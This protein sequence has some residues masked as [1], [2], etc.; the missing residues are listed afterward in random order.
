MISKRASSISPSL[1]FSILEKAQKLQASGID[2]INFSVGEPDFSTAEYI[3]TAAKKAM[4]TG[5]TKYT[6]TGGVEPLR[7]AI[8]EK[9]KKDNGLQYSPDQIIVSNG[10]KQSLDNALACLVDPGDEVILFS[11]YWLTYPELVKICGGTPVIVECD[12]ANNYFPT[13]EQL[14]K[15]I[16]PKT[17]VILLNTPCN[18]SGAV[19]PEKVI[20]ELAAVIEKTD[21]YVISD[22]IYEKLIYDGT[23]HYSIAAYSKKLYEK[24]IVINGFSKAFAM[25]GWRV[26]YLAASPKIAKAVIAFQSHVTQ[27]INTPAQY[28]AIEALSN[29]QGDT[30]L[31]QMIAEFKKRAEYLISRLEKMPH[32]SFTRPR[33]AFY[34]L[35]D[36]TKLGDA[37]EIASQLLEK[38]HIAVVPGDPFG[39]GGTVRLSY[40]LGMEEITKG[41][42]RLEEFLL[43]CK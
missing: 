42:N 21:A 41:M 7:Q 38:A 26:G 11:P 5:K 24:T 14:E 8:C 9:L 3:I 25:T 43:S 12:A 22:E 23:K 32:I 19:Y 28:A 1:V 15:A 18:P 40:A 17:K 37:F 39:A 36:V 35:I 6:A 4:D 20:R 16:T 31:K 13:A 10:C 27:N 33:G 29:K 30:V 2:I 34:V